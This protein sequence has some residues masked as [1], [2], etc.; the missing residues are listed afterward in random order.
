MQH[1]HTTLTRWGCRHERERVFVQQTMKSIRD[2]QSQT[3]SCAAG[4]VHEG[5]AYLPNVSAGHD[6]SGSLDQSSTPVGQG[7]ATSASQNGP[8]GG[9]RT[10]GAA[11]QEAKRD[12]HARGDDIGSA[13]PSGDTALMVCITTNVGFDQY[14]FAHPRGDAAGTA[15]RQCLDE[16]DEVD[17]HIVA[18]QEHKLGKHDHAYIPE[19]KANDKW[20]WLG[21][22]GDKKGK[23]GLGFFLRKG[24]V[25]QGSKATS[26]EEGEVASLL[27]LV[28]MIK[29]GVVNTYWS[30]KV[31]DE[32]L[33]VMLSH[34]RA[35][36]VDLLD[37]GAR[38][39]LLVGDL[40]VNMLEGTSRARRL[41]GEMR[42]A[43]GM[44]R[45]D[46][47]GHNSNWV[48]HVRG[49]SHLD[50]LAIRANCAHDVK[51]T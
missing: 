38:V 3:H 2:F 19:L 33:T 44:R 11:R 25:V 31:T 41:I 43:L 24:V 14:G 46:M 13:P 4:L 7:Q 26:L 18:V 6:V 42:D 45:L 23:R 30:G 40:N 35:S 21:F 27:V 51:S 39:V 8:A 16:A 5:T 1:T 50:C 15:L 17:A 48:T 34:V 12:G 36:I 22:P 32:S 47:E 37:Q 28:H 29:I 49:A 9:R 20:E 10:C